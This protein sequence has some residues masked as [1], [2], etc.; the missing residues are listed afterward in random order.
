VAESVGRGV[1]VPGPSAA[2]LHPSQASPCPYWRQI[3]LLASMIILSAWTN[4]SMQLLLSW[5]AGIIV[6][7]EGM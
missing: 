1:S 4:V 6:P 3:R 7:N 2:L 5:S